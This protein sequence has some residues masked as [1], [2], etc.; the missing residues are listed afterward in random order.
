MRK[1]AL[2][3]LEPII[4]S[5]GLVTEIQLVNINSNLS[6]WRDKNIE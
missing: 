6:M 4:S 3:D 2:L 5:Y 1:T